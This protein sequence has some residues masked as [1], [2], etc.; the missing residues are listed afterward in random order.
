MSRRYYLALALILLLATAANAAP[1]LYELVGVQF[2][3]GGTA[4]GYFEYDPATN[5]YSNVNITTTTGGVRTGAT[6]NFVC[7]QDVP[8]CVGVSPN[9]TQAL[10]LTST[11]ANQTGMPG[12]ALFFTG[13]GGTAGLGSALP[14]PYPRT[15]QPWGRL[16]GGGHA[17]GRFCWN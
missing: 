10:Y 4:S 11:A 6:Y 16:C 13:V 15:L 3:D 5:L 7:G 17:R 8:T 1:T 2:N 12:F 14:D 9:S